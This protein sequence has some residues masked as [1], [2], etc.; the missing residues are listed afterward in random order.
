MELKSQLLKPHILLINQLVL[1]D[2]SFLFFPDYLIE[3]LNDTISSFDLLYSLSFLEVDSSWTI[4]YF[5][6]NSSN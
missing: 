4:W 1:A 2:N 3:L 6:S 5:S